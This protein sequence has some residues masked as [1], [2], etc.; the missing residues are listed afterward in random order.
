M[1]EE[2]LCLKRKKKNSKLSIK[3]EF[4]CPCETRETPALGKTGERTSKS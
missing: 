4:R 1:T 2:M 3:V